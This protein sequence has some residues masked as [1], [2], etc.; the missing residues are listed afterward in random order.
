MQKLK[1]IIKKIIP[2]RFLPTSRW[3]GNFS[4]WDEALNLSS[5]YDVQ[6]VF[7][8]VANSTRKVINGEAAYERDSVLFD[9][10]EYSWPLLTALLWVASQNKGRLSLIDFG[11]ALGSSYY[12]SRNF[13]GHLEELNWNIVEQEG[14]VKL[15]QK[16]FEQ[17][18]VKFYSTIENCLAKG[19]VDMV[20]LSCVT[21]YLESPYQFI[22]SLLGFKIPYILVDRTPLLGQNPDRLTIDKVPDSIYSATIPTWFLNQDKF[23]KAFKGYTLISDF[24]SELSQLPLS[25]PVD[26]AKNI[27]MLFKLEES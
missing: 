1:Q 22:D 27:G 15:G 6:E 19:S 5:S 4:T 8:R 16:E 20:L 9:K 21:P 11:G 12:Q 18:P 13:L 7:D 3:K 26:C 14:F 25:N 2:R 10:I 23:E 17:G 24:Q